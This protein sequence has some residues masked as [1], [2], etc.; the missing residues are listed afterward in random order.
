MIRRSAVRPV[1]LVIC[2]VALLLGL[3]R[4]AVYFREPQ[5]FATVKTLFDLQGSRPAKAKPIRSLA[6]HATKEPIS[7]ASL[8][9]PSLPANEPDLIVAIQQELARI[10]Y[11]GGP[12]TTAWSEGVRDAVR[13]ISGSGR[14]KPS[15]QLLMTLRAAKPEIK[16][17]VGRLGATLNLQAAQDLINGRIPAIPVVTPEEGLLSEGYLPPWAALHERYSQLSQSAQPGAGDNGA[18]LTMRVTARSSRAERGRHERISRR[19][20]YASVHRRSRFFS[21]FGGYFAY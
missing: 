21:P 8:A 20:S 5:N 15:P 18:A 7:Q 6:S 9:T 2:T 4:L 1:I 17:H 11:Y 13:K 3:P 10:G 19:H 14:T 12:I 16:S